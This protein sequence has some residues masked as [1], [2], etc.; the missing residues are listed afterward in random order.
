MPIEGNRRN[1][2]TPNVYPVQTIRPTRQQQGENQTNENVQNPIQEV[3]I[4]VGPEVYRQYIVN[5]TPIAIKSEKVNDSENDMREVYELDKQIF[6]DQDPYESYEEFRNIV[7]NNQLST[8][9][10]RDENNH[11]TILGYY[12]LEPI[13]NGDLYIDSIGLKPEYRNTRKGYYTIKYAWEKILDYATENGANTLSLHV[14]ASNRNLVRMYQNLGF[15][16]KETLNNYYA[17]GTDAYYM[18][19]PVEENQSNTE[20][21]EPQQE[22]VQSETQAENQ[23]EEPTTTIQEEETPVENNNVIQTPEVP[24]TTTEPEQQENIETANQLEEEQAEILL[25]EKI[26]QAKNELLEMGIAENEIKNYLNPCI[27]KEPSNKYQIF[28]DDL[29]ECGKYLIQT[30][31]KYSED[32]EIFPYGFS[33]YQYNDTLNSLCDRDSSGNICKVRKD[34]LPYIDL[35]VQNK[36]HFSNYAK[37]F[38]KSKEEYTDGTNCI[39]TKGLDLAIALRK[40]IGNSYIEDVISACLLHKQDNSKTFSD[41]AISTVQKALPQLPEVEG[42]SLFDILILSKVKDDNGDEK[43]DIELFNGLTKAILGQHNFSDRVFY[44]ASE[45]IDANKLGCDTK[46]LLDYGKKVWNNKA[47][48]DITWKQ[49]YKTQKKINAKLFKA[50]TYNAT[51]Y[52]KTPTNDLKSQTIVLFDDEVLN[53]FIE[54]QSAKPP[55]FENPEA[56]AEILEACK[57]KKQSYSS[58]K[59]NPELL[60]KAFQL[61]QYGVEEEHIAECIEACKLS[62]INPYTGELEK[63]EFSDEIYNKIIE[64]YKSQDSYNIKHFVNY[65]KPSIDMVNGQEI[66][67]PNNLERLL[68]SYVRIDDSYISTK[69]SSM[70]FF[71]TTDKYNR[72]FDI[73][74]HEKCTT[75]K[76]PMEL[77]F[78]RKTFGKNKSKFIPSERLIDAY[79]K[80]EDKNIKFTKRNSDYDSMYCGHPEQYIMEACRSYNSFN[81]YKFDFQAYNAAIELIDKGYDGRDVLDILYQCQVNK[82][83]QDCHFSQTRYG[84]IKELLA[85]G[86]DLQNAGNIANYCISENGEIDTTTLEQC[87]ELYNLGEKTPTTAISIVKKDPIAYERLKQAIK[88]GLSYEV[89]KQCHI[90][91]KFQ[92]RIFKLALNLQDR[93][94]SPNNISDLINVCHEKTDNEKEPEIFNMDIYNNIAKL[95]ELGIEKDNIA[96]ILYACKYKHTNKYYPNAY[97]KVSKLHYKN[98]DDKGIIQFLTSCYK[99]EKFNEEKYNE[100]LKLCS[101]HEVLK[102]QTHDDTYVV[103]RIADNASSIKEITELFGEDVMNNVVTA[104]IDNYINFVNQCTRLKRECSDAFIEDLKTRLDTLPSPEIKVKRLRIL[105]SLAGKVDENALRTLTHLIHSPEMTKEQIDLANKIFTD[106]T[107]DY[108]TCVE[109]FIREINA[110]QNTKNILREY[111]QQARLDKQ[112]DTPKPIEEQMAQMDVFAQQML[113]NPQTPLEKKLKYIDEY[114]I[115]KADMKSHPEKYTTPKIFPKPL[116][117]LKRMVVSYVNIPNADAEFNSSMLT[118]MYQHY[119]IEINDDLIKTIHFDSKYFDKLFSTTEDFKT[120]F[121]RLIELQKIHPERPLTQN[122]LEMPTPGTAEYEEYQ[123][124][125]L[126]EQIKANQDTARQFR[127][128]GLNFG[129]WNT[130]DPNLK[131]NTFTVEA[132]PD[133][134]YKNTTYN[135]INIFQDEFFQKIKPEETEK[136]MKNLTAQGYTIFNNNLYKNGEQIKNNDLEKFTETV[137]NY[138]T[139]NEYWQSINNPNCQLTEDEKTGIAAFTDHLKDIANH[140]K[141]IRGAK[142]VNDIY[143]RLSDDNN[144]GRNIFFGNHVGCCNSVDSSFAGYSAPMHLLNNFNRGIELVDK[145]GNSYGNSMCFFAD[146]DGKLTFVID[147]F[148]ANGKLGSNPIVTDELIKFGKRICK[149]MGREDAQIMIGPNYNHIDE[150]RLKSVNVEQMKILGTVSEET[151]CD[152]VGGSKVKEAINNGKENIRMKIYE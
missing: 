30:I 109:K 103:K 127:E 69:P 38:T 19:R 22:I 68:K 8:Y 51:R 57:E 37:I 112:I 137:T 116:E 91:G 60:E 123:N 128:H 72:T 144:I 93:K 18:E 96:G 74:L 76:V 124:L 29:F 104:K 102:G 75:T 117:N 107:T 129:K 21:S 71:K 4:H 5:H 138:I 78:E 41:Q 106:K 100:L 99:D 3:Q 67:R 97:E 140:I 152:S 90:N 131:S 84:K 86:I 26:E 98:F 79:L 7:Q 59:Y 81:D 94:F 87:I 132:D 141:E 9:V 66:F 92:D 125:G 42:Y 56:A 150:S 53:K 135:L 151:Y 80:L 120:N 20:I 82:Y 48:S 17:N 2:I 39:T 145:Y 121:R 10:V 55:V 146:M 85:Q 58:Y 130:F 40:Y 12:Q 105:G 54:L 6:A 32:K 143:L 148:E 134:E 61:K 46:A 44:S 27:I 70:D 24:I 35:F 101:K 11:N 115:K 83:E 110:P 14:D 77:I 25:N 147:S 28:N 64:P 62:N 89:I 149:E 113:T 23:I 122:R 65:I 33:T 34:L 50:C 119:K 13:N 63:K 15:T 95:E 45:I 118:A 47:I 108:E 36:I 136:L 73:D 31:Q 133:T 52:I 16:I 43:F 49:E 114:K 1:N 126:I 88:R 111:L 142:T 139:Q